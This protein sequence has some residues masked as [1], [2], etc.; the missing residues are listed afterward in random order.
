MPRPSGTIGRVSRPDI[1]SVAYFKFADRSKFTTNSQVLRCT[2]SVRVGSM[3]L[4][5]S[6]VIIGEL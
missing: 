3:L 1:R 6:L 2:R 4:K 5:K